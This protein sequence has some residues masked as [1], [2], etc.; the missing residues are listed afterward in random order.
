MSALK[1]RPPIEQATSSPD[2]LRQRIRNIRGHFG[3]QAMHEGALDPRRHRPRFLVNRHDP[4]GVNGRV[5]VVG[6]AANDFELRVGQLESTR[7][8]ELHGAVKHNLLAR[9]EYVLEKCL[10]GKRRT[11]GPGGVPD[12]ELED[13]EAGPASRTNAGRDYLDVDRGGRT[14]TETRDG[15]Q[16]GAVL[17]SQ[18]KPE[19]Q[20]FYREQADPFEVG[21]ASGT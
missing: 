1:G 14:G 4:P 9:L 15:T 5:L 17:V 2:R 3:K 11:R 21:C 6:L 20:V 8:T 10:I 18:R 16:G 19:Q 7:S 13:P 12:D